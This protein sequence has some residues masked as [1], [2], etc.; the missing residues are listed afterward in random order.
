[1][2]TTSTTTTTLHITI[3]SQDGQMTN[4]QSKQ[5]YDGHD[6]DVDETHKDNDEDD[7]DKYSV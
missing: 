2:T 6:D 1:M 4:A 3:W 5:C 7:A